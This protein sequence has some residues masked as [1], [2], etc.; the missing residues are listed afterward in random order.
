LIP[1]VEEKEEPLI[2][3]V[4][5][6]AEPQISISKPEE[7]S[8]FTRTKEEN[9]APITEKPEEK[10]REDIFGLKPKPTG[11]KRFANPFDNREAK[12]WKCSKCGAL[13]PSFMAI[14]ECGT[15]K[16]GN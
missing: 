10:E 9:R 2:P 16:R 14:C 11:N 13:R 8:V 3:I 12:E 1:M 4:E 7:K 5:E 6:K 15:S